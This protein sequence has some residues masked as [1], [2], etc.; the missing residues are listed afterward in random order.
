MKKSVIDLKP[1]E[2][3]KLASAAWKS[4]AQQAMG[5]ALPITGSRDGRRFRYYPDGRVVDLGPIEE[6][7]D[8]DT[9]AENANKQSV[10]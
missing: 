1:E 8:V 10:A 6:L 4:A 2:V 7:P 9:A 5:E 3:D